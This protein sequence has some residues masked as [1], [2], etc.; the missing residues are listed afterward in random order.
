MTTLLEQHLGDEVERPTTERP[1]RT[2]AM[3]FADWGLDTGSR[4]GA[5]FARTSDELAEVLDD[6]DEIIPF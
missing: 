1:E 3:M 5:F 2:A 6:D 4:I